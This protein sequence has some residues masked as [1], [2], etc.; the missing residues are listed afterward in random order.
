MA[1]ISLA[2]LLQIVIPG[3]SEI[4]RYQ[5]YQLEPLVFDEGLYSF[6][7]FEIKSYPQTDLSMGSEDTVVA[8]RNSQLLRAILRTYNNLR[9]AIVTVVHIQPGL[10][11]PP[12]GYR[13]SISTTTTE[14]GA[15]IFVLKSPTNALT[16]ALAGKYISAA[17][18]PE[19]PY[20]L[21]QL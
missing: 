2:T 15:V 17:D 9:G 6:A 21:P 20:Y 3:S 18:F 10:D 14:G 13:L 16:G 8:I 4:L 12:I 1:A 7:A 11:V 5:N 19:L